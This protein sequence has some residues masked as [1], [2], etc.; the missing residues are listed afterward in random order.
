MDIKWTKEQLQATQKNGSNILVAAAAGSGKTAVLVER[1]IQKIVTTQIDIDK[2]LV[3]TFTNAAASEMKERVL[4]AIYKRIE[5]EPNNRNLQKQITLLNKASICTIH[6]FCLQIIRE[7]FYKTDISCNFKIAET[8]EI[9][10]IKQAVLEDLFDE[11]YEKNDSNFLK[12]IDTYASYRGDEKLK[13]IIITLYE[14]LQSMPFPNEALTEMIEAFCI[15]ENIE[16]SDTSWGKLILELAKEQLETAISKLKKIQKKLSLQPE[17]SGCFGI[18]SEDIDLIESLKTSSINWDKLYTDLQNLSFSKWKGDAKV[19]SNLKDEAKMVRDE[20]KDIIKEITKSISYDS[21]AAIQNTKSMYDILKI[22][23]EIIFEFSGAYEKKKREKNILDFN[24]IE[25]KALEILLCKD[26]LGN[27][28]PSDVA[29]IMQSKF[30]EIAIDEY[31]DSNLVQEYILKSVSNGKNIFM[32]GDVKQSIY[33][34]R[35]A[36]PELFLDKYFT[37]KEITDE[38][39]NENTK[40]KLFEN[41]RSRKNILD[42]TNL[43]FNSIMSKKL[44]DIDYTTEEYLNPGADYTET[45]QVKVAAKSELNIITLQSSDETIVLDKSEVEAKFVTRRIKELFKNNI[46]VY[47]KKI[48]YRE[49]KYKD[50]VILLRATSTLAPVIERELQN[51]SLP[52]YSDS[53]AEYLESVE[54]QTMISLL[55]IIDN[56]DNDIP[57]VTVL[58]SVIGGFTDDELV[59]IRLLR[60]SK[61]FYAAL[62]IA[63]NSEKISE[64]VRRK[65]V[66]FVLLLDSFKREEEHLPLDELIWKIYEDTGYYN[67][68]QLMNN[69]ELRIANLKMLFQ[70]AKDYGK[71]SFKG[72]FNFI[73]YIEKLKI[74]NG[75]L[76]SAKIIGENDDVIRIMSIHKSKG[77]EFPIV[78]LCGAGKQMN[79]QELNENL[80]FHPELGLGP[81]YID[82]DRKIHFVTPAKEAIKQKIKSE[83]ISEEMRILYVAL[84]R[85]KEKLIITGT[86]KEADEMCINEDVETS[87]TDF[88][89][90]P[91][92]ILRKSKSYLDWFKAVRAFNKNSMDGIIQTN[93]INADDVLKNEEEKEHVL[94]SP[95]DNSTEKVE[96]EYLSEKLLWKYKYSE[97]SKIEGKTSVSK[98]K[99]LNNEENISEIKMKPQFLNDNLEITSAEK[100]TLVHLFMQKM[101]LRKKYADQELENLKI[102][103]TRNKII[104]SKEADAIDLEPIKK[105]VDSDLAEEI[106]NSKQIYKEEPFYINIPANEIYETKLEDTVLVQGIIDLYYITNDGKVVLVDYKTDR[107]QNELELIEKYKVQLDLYKKALKEALKREVAAVYIYSLYLNKLINVL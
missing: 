58:R 90:V 41:F 99:N 27:Y 72:L 52:V 51:E 46:Y 18:I 35:Q 106:R 81:E 91:I 16:F 6:S 31:Q 3:V 73:N 69:G 23:G 53:T 60:K 29:Q 94:V 61:S 101:D 77:L 50:V 40:I 85:A 104:S 100:G 92:S 17:L 20:V 14:K 32:V 76:S 8:T 65:I 84:T 15:N 59:E 4:E 43:V 71:A 88:N 37:Y 28:I 86:T 89:Q 30:T 5:I 95:Y 1:I 11:L 9:E 10:L 42:I 34:F 64:S 24:D 63:K 44:G 105:F 25:H 79:F 22:V 49:L 62:K 26:E 57:L 83:I 68:V 7:Y 75:D 2:L 39:N 107:V 47:D 87:N 93:V 54:I 82:Y 67:Y 33:K 103:L 66:S 70:R 78:F 56:P 48:G 96:V 102:E 80:L 38:D 45:S 19:V 13:E 97:L 12:L 98:V 21:K 74:S 36:M 55:K